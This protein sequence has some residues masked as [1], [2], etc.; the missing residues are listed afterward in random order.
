MRRLGIALGLLI[1]LLLVTAPRFDQNDP[2]PL[3]GIT[4]TEQGGNLGDA[5][6]YVRFVEVI[7]GEVDGLPP[8]PFRYR[9]LT[10]LLA[11]PLP[12]D[13]LTSINVV[14]VVALAAAT[15][16]LWLILNALGVGERMEVL[17]CLL[18][19]VSFPTFYYGAIGYVD[20]LSIAFIMIG[21][22]ALLTDRFLVMLLL[23]PLA[24]V[25]RETTV[26]LVP[27]GLAWM[28]VRGTGR[29]STVLWLLAWI[30][31]FGVTLA[32]VR[33]GLYDDGTNLW[34]PSLARARENLSRPRTWLSGLLAIGVPGLIIAVNLRRLPS[35]G[36]ER[37]VL[38]GSGALLSIGLFAY[39]VLA[40]Y[41]DGRFLWPIYAFTVPTAILLLVAPDPG[42]LS[43][44]RAAVR[45]VRRI[46]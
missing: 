5:E 42:A 46:R 15:A 10:P 23:L 40:A 45:D 18:F 13:A 11:A 12:F 21:T 41:A 44:G 43:A 37:L 30:G 27:L 3:A 35:L 19:I 33:W 16:G 7:R 4:G 36:R 39:A 38:F 22:A 34:R 2:G 17:G 28:L 1:A 26:I 20:P 31:A 8:A 25:A 6:Y 32:L 24:A 29:R 9:P 14:N